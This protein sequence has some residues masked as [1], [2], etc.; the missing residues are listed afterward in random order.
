MFVMVPLCMGSICQMF[1]LS[2]T[3][4]FFSLVVSMLFWV[5]ESMKEREINLHKTNNIEARA[6]HGHTHTTHKWKVNYVFKITKK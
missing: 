6:Y 2:Q 3:G 4:N 1:T 5:L